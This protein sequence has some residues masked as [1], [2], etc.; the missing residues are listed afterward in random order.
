MHKKGLDP[1]PDLAD[2]PIDPMD[3]DGCVPP[4]GIFR[5]C[6]KPCRFQG[7]LVAMINIIQA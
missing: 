1:E 2:E 4:Q 5:E 7:Y 3:V 6:K